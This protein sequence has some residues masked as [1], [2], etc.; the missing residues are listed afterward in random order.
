MG[1][2]GNA[3]TIAVGPLDI[4]AGATEKIGF[5]I[6]S[7]AN[8]SELITNTVT[9]KNKYAAT[10]SV[11]Q[12]SEL[13]PNK[14]ELYQNYPNPFNPTTIIK[15][16][17]PKNDFVRLKVYDI[18]GKE[19]AVLLNGELEA[20]FYEFTFDAS[21]LSSGMYFYKVE[22]NNFVDTKKMLFIK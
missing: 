1:P 7:G 12:I 2:G 14:Y 20:G 19:V 6:V 16:A 21:R 11:K 22:T 4:D 3:M 8:L 18:L 17:V 13:I 5:A 15:F 10:I 9:A